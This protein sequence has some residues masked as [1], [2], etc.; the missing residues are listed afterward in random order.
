MR[1]I[2]RETAIR[3]S[4]PTARGSPFSPRGNF[5]CSTIDRK[6]SNNAI[7]G[8]RHEVPYRLSGCHID[9][10]GVG[11]RFRCCFGATAKEDQSGTVSFGYG[12]GA[13]GR[14]TRSSRPAFLW[15]GAPAASG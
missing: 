6:G 7:R 14:A 1:M 15:G 11:T 12:G 13:G 2:Q 8:E 10:L 5:C 3:H 4:I 9:D